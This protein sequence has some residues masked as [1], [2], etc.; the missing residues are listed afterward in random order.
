MAVSGE[1]VAVGLKVAVLVIAVVGSV[2]FA[3]IFAVVVVAAGGL[4]ADS[5][6]V[7]VVESFL[8]HVTVTVDGFG[9]VGSTLLLA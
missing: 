2:E 5:V 1:H 3:D 6:G 4:V 9:A 7:G 8:V